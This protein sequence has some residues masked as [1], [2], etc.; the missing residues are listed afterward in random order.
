[1]LCFKICNHS[2]I[3]RR[4][5]VRFGKFDTTI[6]PVIVLAFHLIKSYEFKGARLYYA[7]TSAV[8]AN[9]YKRDEF[10]FTVY[11]L[12]LGNIYC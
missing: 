5:T 8:P 11:Y 9:S 12:S 6:N 1:M 2:H 3:L 7:L 10:L 4:R